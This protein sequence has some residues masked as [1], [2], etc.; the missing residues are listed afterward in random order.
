MKVVRLRNYDIPLEMVYGV[1]LHCKNDD[2][3]KVNE[4]IMH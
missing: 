3:F 2:V 4:S 1:P